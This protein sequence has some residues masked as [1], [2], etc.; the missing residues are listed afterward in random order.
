MPIA[1]S[2]NSNLLELPRFKKTVESSLAPRALSLVERN[3]AIKQSTIFKKVLA[4]FGMV[5]ILHIPLMQAKIRKSMILVNRD[6]YKPAHLRLAGMVQKHII[7]AMQ[8]HYWLRHSEVNEENLAKVQGDSVILEVSKDGVIDSWSRCEEAFLGL[9]GPSEVFPK[10]VP[11]ELLKWVKERAR[12]F[13]L[14]NPEQNSTSI[15]L[16]ESPTQYGTVFLGNRHGKH[17]LLIHKPQEF[18]AGLGLTPRETEVLSWL[19]QGKTNPEIAI[20]LGISRYT[21][22]NHVERILAKLQ[23]DHRQQAMA[24]A[25]KWFGH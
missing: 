23:V 18:P 25:R 13:P 15:P 22:R 6:T 11:E 7:A 8:N 14:S 17:K 19:C 24:M 12:T 5:D 3:E 1:K 9:M 4:P 2:F 21:A 20:I 10:K 16:T